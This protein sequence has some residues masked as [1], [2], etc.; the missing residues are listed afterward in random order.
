MNEQDKA[1]RPNTATE[2]L[3]ER[4]KKEIADAVTRRDPGRTMPFLVSSGFH[5]VP[6]EMINAMARL[7]REA[8]ALIYDKLEVLTGTSGSD[9]DLRK[10]RERWDRHVTIATWKPEPEASEWKQAYV[11]AMAEREDALVENETLK[12]R[13]RENAVAF[14]QELQAASANAADDKRRADNAILAMQHKTFEMQAERDEAR[15]AVENLQEAFATLRQ[16]PAVAGL[17]V[18]TK[19]MFAR[20]DIVLFEKTKQR[21]TLFASIDAWLAS[22]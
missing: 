1:D 19:H 17:L 22:R 12:D 5:I 16:D 8:T 14:A 13:L 4:I 10:T 2:M 15:E 18:A 21:D 3:A 11:R 7:S 6:D 9:E 20:T